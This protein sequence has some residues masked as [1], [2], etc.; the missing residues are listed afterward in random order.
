MQ[1]I[2]RRIFHILHFVLWYDGTISVNQ[3][4]SIRNAG[5]VLSD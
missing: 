3:S 1:Y 5:F 4:A 2:K